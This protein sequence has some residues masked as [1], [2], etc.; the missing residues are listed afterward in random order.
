MRFRGAEVSTISCCNF[1][2]D[3]SHLKK[4]WLTPLPFSRSVQEIVGESRI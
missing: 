1:S 2:F 3:P 4:G